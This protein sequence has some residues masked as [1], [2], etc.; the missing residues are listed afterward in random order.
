[1]RYGAS[2]T[3]AGGKSAYAAVSIAGESDPVLGR[4]AVIADGSGAH[5]AGLSRRRHD[6]EQTA[7]VAKVWCRRPPNGLAYERFTSDGPVALLPEN[8]HYGLVWTGSPAAVQALLATDDATFLARLALRFGSRCTGFTAV[9]QRRSFPLVLELAPSTVSARCAVIGNAAQALH[10][11]AG[12]GFNLGLRDAFELAR[13]VIDTPVAAIGS[14]AM[15]ARYARDRRPD[16]W[17]GVAL[18]HGLLGLFGNASPWLRWPRG[19]ALAMLDAMPPAKH[20]FTHAMLFGAH[21]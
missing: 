16:R 2:V 15:L 19:I 10:P 18:T 12:Q 9:A 4:L 20:M 3:H 14:P 6:Y 11:V 5:V 21:L 13:I 17:A 8:D 1:M 7:L